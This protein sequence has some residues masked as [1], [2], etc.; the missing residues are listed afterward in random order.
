MKHTFYP[1]WV[2]F[3][4]SQNNARWMELQIEVAELELGLA[5]AKVRNASAVALN[6][7][8]AE[9]GTDWSSK[10]GQSGQGCEKGRKVS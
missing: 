7:F 10:L 2:I 8:L 1:H 6:Y 3:L 5:R 9:F 4:I